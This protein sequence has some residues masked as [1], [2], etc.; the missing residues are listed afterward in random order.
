[1]F[2]LALFT[3]TEK[4]RGVV[5]SSVCNG[6]LLRTTFT[7]LRWKTACVKVETLYIVATPIYVTFP[8]NI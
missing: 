3:E 8:L 6:R 2:H 1:M 4:L 7:S 5:N